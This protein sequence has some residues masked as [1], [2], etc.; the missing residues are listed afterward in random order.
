M[1]PNHLC[2]SLMTDLL[3]RHKNTHFIYPVSYH[4]T[5]PWSNFY[6]RTLVR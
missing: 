6:G 3:S 5:F 1:G 4:G 2:T